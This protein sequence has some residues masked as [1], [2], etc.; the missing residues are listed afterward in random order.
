MTNH[1]VRLSAG[2][3]SSER[4]WSSATRPGVGEKTCFLACSIPPRGVLTL[5]VRGGMAIESVDRH[6]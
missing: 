5:A 3:G 6:L 1:R 2:W 4:G